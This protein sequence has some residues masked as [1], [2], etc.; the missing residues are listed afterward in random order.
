[1]CFSTLSMKHMALSLFV[2]WVFPLLA[3]ADNAVAGTVR[4]ASEAK[5]PPLGDV[6]VIVQQDSKAKDS[7]RDSDGA[8]A[9]DVSSAYK[10]IDIM[11]KKDGYTTAFDTDVDNDKSPNK[12]P[13]VYMAKRG[14]LKKVTKRRIELILKSTLVAAERA[15]SEKLPAMTAAVKEN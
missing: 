11:F 2:C 7:T 14:E 5:A 1:M 8:Y 4:D 3:F 15:T 12:R 9:F 6:K 13:V 10:K